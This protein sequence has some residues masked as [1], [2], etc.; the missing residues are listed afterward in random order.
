MEVKILGDFEHESGVQAVTDWFSKRGYWEAFATDYG[1]GLWTIS[2]FLICR[3]P[4]LNFKQRIRHQKKE[5]TLYMDIMLPFTEFVSASLEEREKKVVEAMLAEVPRIVRKYKFADFDTELFI[6]HFN[7]YFSDLLA[8][9]PQS[10][11]L[12]V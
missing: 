12:A 5:K 4:E 6:S 8:E 7:K 10:P 3:R 1:D 2:I 11:A 9:L